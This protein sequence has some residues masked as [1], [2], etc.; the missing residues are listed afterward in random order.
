M[1]DV[2][3]HCG[4]S[5][6]K[7]SVEAA[8]MLKLAEEVGYAGFVVKDHYVPALLGTKM[9][10]QHLEN[11]TCKV[12]RCLVLNN[13]VGGLNVN[14]VD[15]ARQLGTTMVYLP[16]VSFKTHIDGHKETGF[17]GGASASD[18]EGDPIVISDENGNLH[19]K[20]VEVIE[21][22]AKHDMVLL[23]QKQ[24]INRDLGKNKSSYRPVI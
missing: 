11:G 23:F 14:A 7:R 3:V 18:V 1:Y 17:V 13:A 2:H 6:A 19:P 5:T 24:F 8:E 4:P 15:K 22:L 10:E 16:T 21:Y 12:Y 9:V 20:T